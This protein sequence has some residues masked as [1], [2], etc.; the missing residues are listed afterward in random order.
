MVF[1][2]LIYKLILQFKL[3]KI[4]KKYSQE[5]RYLRIFIT[6][7][8]YLLVNSFWEFGTFAKAF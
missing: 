7:H 2:L 4:H 6:V 3:N 1:E 5:I 8:G